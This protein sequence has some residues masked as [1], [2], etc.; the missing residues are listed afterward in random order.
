[1]YNH[2]YVQKLRWQEG[3]GEPRNAI[4]MACPKERSNTVCKSK[5]RSRQALIT[6]LQLDLEMTRPKY[7]RRTL[8]AAVVQR[9]RSGP[10]RTGHLV[11]VLG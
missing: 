9:T 2:Q 1:M 6:R 10:L 5:S 7:G 3:H 8:K 4:L 11:Q